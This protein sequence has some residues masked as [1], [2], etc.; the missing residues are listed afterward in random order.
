MQK[1]RATNQCVRYS[2]A[3]VVDTGRNATTQLC[4]A[5]V[6]S[7]GEEGALLLLRS[8]PPTCQPKNSLQLSAVNMKLL[9]ASAVAAATP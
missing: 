5:G 8:R 9:P 3:Q 1:R 4:R 6:T 2:S 7:I